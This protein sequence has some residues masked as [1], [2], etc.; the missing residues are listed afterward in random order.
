ML[1]T[2]FVQIAAYRDPELVPT[3]RHCLSRAKHPSRLKF[4]ICYQHDI[5]N[6]LEEFD[7][8]DSV[9]T[10]KIPFTESKGACWARSKTNELYNNEDFTLQ[11][12]SHMRFIQ[13]WDEVLLNMW[14]SLKDPK[15]ILTAY[16]PQYEPGQPEEEWKN[17]PHICNVYAFK[18]GQTEQ[19]PKTPEDIEARD[20]PYRVVHT[21]AGFLFGPGSLIVDVP[22]DPEFYFSGEE[23]ALTVRLFTHGYNLFAPHKTIVYHYYERKDESKHWADDKNWGIYGNV[24]NERLDCLL[25]RSNKHN[26]SKY[27]LGKERTLEDF[28]NYSG[29]DYKRNIV[30]IDTINGKEPPVDLS[31][32]AKWSFIIKTYHQVGVWDF[33]RI[34]K[35]EDP[36]FWAF[37]FKD[38]NG[39]EIFRED[40]SVDNAPD[41]FSGKVFQREFKFEYFY[42]AQRPT[43]FMIWPYSKSKQWLENTIWN[44]S[45]V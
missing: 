22:Y 7:F 21:A 24:S 8:N 31:D 33:S 44:L 9:K 27:G 18:D 25:N 37:I 29:I 45:C 26:L 16:P 39:Q 19:R 23:T 36:K 35:C 3:L 30:H 2:I 1:D 12:D 6:S 4:G 20:T 34:D 10:V 15:A 42:P 28:Q 13:D 40:V 14:K 38:Q 11:I 17:I 41:Y 32:P 5:E 43:T